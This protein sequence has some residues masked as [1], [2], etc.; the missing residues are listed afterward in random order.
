MAAIQCNCVQLPVAAGLLPHGL[1]GLAQLLQNEGLFVPQ[2][3]A[4]LLLLAL[5]LLLA[6][7]GKDPKWVY[8]LNILPCPLGGKRLSVG[9]SGPSSP[10][11]LLFR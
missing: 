9:P 10:H 1:G 11:L 3:S 4:W 5:F 2:G 6:L 8:Y 7:S